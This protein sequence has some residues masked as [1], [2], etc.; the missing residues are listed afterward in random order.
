MTEKPDYRHLFVL[1]K[2]AEM[3]AHRRTA[4]ISTEYLAGKLGTSQQTASRYLIEL[5]NKGWIKRT[6]TPEGCLIKITEA[7][8]KELQKLH[9]NLRFLMESAYPPSITLE[10]T[11]FTGLGEGAY[12]I[13]KEKYQK[14][15]IEKLG[16]DPYPGTLN[17]RLTTDYDV[18]ARS[19]LEAYP[20]IEVEGFRD[21]DR[22]FGHVKCYPATIENKVKGALIL[23]LRTHYDVSVLEI[24]A[25]VFLRKHLKLRDGHKVK[26]EVLTLP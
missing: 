12:Y 16:F 23:A 18:K 25:P 14:Q 24:I 19:E 26:V 10:G 2:L 5:D 21:E 17:L 8:V 9:S 13:S 1:L 3:G 11:V 15:F 20:A 7:G 22:T 6:V 4:R